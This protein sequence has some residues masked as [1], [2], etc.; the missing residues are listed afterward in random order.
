MKRTVSP[1][2]LSGAVLVPGSK[3][4]TIRAL[5]IATLARGTSVLRIPLESADTKSAL[6]LCV[7]LGAEI[8]QEGSGVNALWRVKGTGGAFRPA[9]INVGNSG[10][11]LYLAAAVAATGRQKV[12]FDGDEQIRRRSAAPLLQALRELGAEVKEDG[13]AGCAP[14]S[15]CGPLK[16]GKVSIEC[17]T[18]QYLSALLLAAPLAPAGKMSEIAVPLLYEQPYAE[19]TLRWLERQGITIFRRKLEWFSIPGGQKYQAFDSCIPAD[20][21]SATFF[22]CAAAITG[23]KLLVRG[24]DPQD[25]QGDKM[26]LPIL[27][28][29]GCRIDY[30]EAGIEIEGPEGRSPGEGLR[31]GVF[32]LN[33]MPDAL[34]ALAATA[35]FAHGESRFINV[36]QARIKETDRIAV[37]ACELAALGAETEELPD[38][39]IIR[40]KGS[41]EGC[42]LEAAY[43][44]GHGD[45]RVIMA[46]AIA[47]LG[48]NR[49]VCI[50]DDTAVAVTFPGFF[51]LL[52]SIREV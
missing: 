28:A 37:M 13:A 35:C 26:V 25:S 30:S 41:L 23:S 11:A 48:A 49:P 36:P 9:S 6:D 7:S 20:F 40:G 17:P 15:V 33:A 46:L 18:S 32:D 44:R 50:D 43:A 52:D 14:F 5:L 21:S 27:E 10:T 51:D 29:M 42:S 2:K 3:S 16:G 24:L 12:A 1:S 39:L 22:F 19:M 34:P 47:A 38:G 4:H 45:H 31:G 8:R